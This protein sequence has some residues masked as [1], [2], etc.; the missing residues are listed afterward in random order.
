MP[1]VLRF[2]KFLARSTIATR[3]PIMGPSTDMS[4]KMPAVCAALSG[5]LTLVAMI[6]ARCGGGVLGIKVAGEDEN[7][8]K[9]MLS[10]FVYMNEA[11]QLT[12][13]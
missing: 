2:G 5:F 1:M 4:A 8:G 7:A 6:A 13:G 11:S 9:S 10:G 3:V 12:K